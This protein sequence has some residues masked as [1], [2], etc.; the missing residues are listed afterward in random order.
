LI[1]ATIPDLEARRYFGPRRSRPAT[2]TGTRAPRRR[3]IST[4]P[5]TVGARTSVGGKD[6]FPAFNPGTDI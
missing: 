5:V 1:M 6:R 2:I 4:S 3:A